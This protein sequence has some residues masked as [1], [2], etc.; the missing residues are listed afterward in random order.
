MAESKKYLTGEIIR[1]IITG[2]IAT[3]VDFGVSSLVAAFIPDSFDYWEYVI[4]TACGFIVSLI[5]NYFLSA[6]WVY[7]HAD[8]SIN[9]KSPKVIGLFTIFSLIGLF[10]GIGIMIG[11]GAIDKYFIDSKFV[12][13]LKFITDSKNYDFS[14]KAFL[15]ACLFYGIKTLI[16]LTWNYLSRK[17]FIFKSKA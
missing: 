17:F 12:D 4:C 11:F 5:V 7:K 16:V 13:W 1:F 2:V 10:I 15:F 6:Y 3:L 8:E 9:K 14:V